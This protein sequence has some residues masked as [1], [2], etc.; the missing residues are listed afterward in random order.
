MAGIVRVE[1]GKFD[2]DLVGE[3]K[4]FKTPKRPS[5]VV[6][7]TDDNGVQGW[8]QSVPI[9]T[10]TYET[11]ESVETTLRHYLAPILLGADPSGLADI[12]ARMDRAIR[13]SFSVGQPLCKAAID[14][15]CYDL[16]GKQTN[17]SVSEILGGARQRQV[18]LSWTINTPTIAE[19]EMQLAQARSRGYG[20]FN[21]KIG[22][23]QSQDYDLQ[24]V[25]TVCN[26][27][28]GGFH[29]ADANTSYDL[30]TALAMAPRLAD[31]GLKALESPLP[32]N[33]LRGYQTLTRQGALPILMDEGIVSPV[34]VAEFIALEML[35]GIAMKVARCG[36]L[37]NA[38]RIVTLLRDN[39]LLVFGSG[40][41]D[42]DL[43]LAA[44]AHLFAC[45]GL[46]RPTALNGPQYIAD[47][48]TT[49]PAFRASGDLLPVPTAPG[50]GIA[51]DASAE[52]SL[53]IAAQGLIR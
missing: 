19:A 25:R 17:R 3:F 33:L 21:I 30:E 50:L 53:S 44:T 34:E 49:D 47:R 22:Y 12:H 43:S 10:W 1:V 20:N 42:P 39:G 2:Y 7:L 23:P 9:E 14:L 40:L 38:S 11:A 13:P 48:G 46:D 18:R 45:A 24:L 6:R 51:I 5:V 41:T 36:G 27:S 29:W 15:A 52:K 37:W 16:W 26:F 4:F 28:P 35:D 32:P 8:G 31:A